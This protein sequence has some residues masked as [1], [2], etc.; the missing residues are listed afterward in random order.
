VHKASDDSLVAT[1]AYD[2]QGRRVS[3]TVDDT[4]THYYY[5]T[6]WRVVE[7]RVA[8]GS[9]EAMATAQYLYRPGSDTPVLEWFFLNGG[10]FI[11]P[12]YYTTDAFGKVTALVDGHD[13][14]V[15]ERYVYDPYGAVTFLQ[16][17]Q[18]GQTEW[19]PTEVEDCA[20]GT[21]STVASE[22]LY[23]GYRYD[24]ETSLYQLRNRQYDPSTGRFLQRDPSGYN[25]T[26]NLYGYAGGNPVTASDPMGLSE[27]SMSETWKAQ[28][29][30]IW[31]YSFDGNMIWTNMIGR[32]G[33]SGTRTINGGT[34]LPPD[35]FDWVSYGGMPYWN[36]VYAGSTAT[37]ALTVNGKSIQSQPGAKPNSPTAKPTGPDYPGMATKIA[38]ER[39]V[40]PGV[41]KGMIMQESG[42]NDK[43]KSGVG[44]VGL[45]QLMPR[46]AMELGLK[47]NPTSDERLD[48]AKNIDAGTRYLKQMYDRMP[49]G[50]NEVE[51]WRL[52]LAAYNCGAGNVNKA[53]KQAGK[54]GNT[55]NVAFS[56]IAPFLSK[57]TQN[58]VQKILGSQGAPAGYA[59]EYGYTMP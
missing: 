27:V 32:C 57:E 51:R 53:L 45:T 58:Y 37:G 44:A 11:E 33:E 26:M 22:I 23:A 52:A 4:T 2:G 41:L 25:G 50:A 18:Y 31:D 15:L 49:E 43:A 7:E 9:G 34:V 19:M 55:G 48:P 13:G 20:A 54:V 59:K 35:C 28:F 29:Y 12:M 14:M 10:E 17:N 30:S 3:K 6:S 36:Q 5:D 42:W 24:P 21:A 39:K 38:I 47:V 56:E 40:P 46:T 8:Y 16:G 1:Y